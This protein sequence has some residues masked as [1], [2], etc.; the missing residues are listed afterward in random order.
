MKRSTLLRTGAALA[1]CLTGVAIASRL[2]RSPEPEGRAMPALIP[3]PSSQVIS[4]DLSAACPDQPKDDDLEAGV[5]WA[6][7]DFS[8]ADGRPYRLQLLARN[9]KTFDCGPKE[10]VI[11]AILYQAWGDGARVAGVDRLFEVGKFGQAPD[12]SSQDVR[13][14]QLGKTAAGEDYFAVR[15]LWWSGQSANINAHSAVIISIA[16]VGKVGVSIASHGDIDYD[17]EGCTVEPA[18]GRATRS[19]RQLTDSDCDGHRPFGYN[20]KLRFDAT[21]PGAPLV[22]VEVAPG[23]TDLDE[24]SLMRI[25]ARDR[26]FRQ[27]R[28]GI[29]QRV[30]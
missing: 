24:K 23:G 16:A 25:P 1:V 22:V 11:S 5:P 17:I 14:D 3:Q 30:R 2:N 8:G 19:I 12:P 7:A 18:T 26:R 10:S 28:N 13:V 21:S 15:Y 9:W 29:Y 20:G 27:D 6:S 4:S